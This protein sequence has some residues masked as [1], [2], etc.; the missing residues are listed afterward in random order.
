MSKLTWS[1]VALVLFLVALPVLSLG[2]TRGAP[3]AWWAGLALVAAA[4]VI[5]PALRYLGGD[6]VAAESAA[7]ESGAA[8]SEET[9]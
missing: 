6:G 4:G 3:V 7:P 1:L 9:K 5:P 8:D 2:T